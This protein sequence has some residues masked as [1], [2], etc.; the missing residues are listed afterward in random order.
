M[1]HLEEAEN[2]EKRVVGVREEDESVGLRLRF[3]RERG[4]RSRGRRRQAMCKGRRG[5]VSGRIIGS[6]DREKAGGCV[7]GRREGVTAERDR[8]WC[9]EDGEGG[10]A[11]F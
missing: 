5:G 8:W 1:R 7:G 4:A 10:G 11:A 2:E 9:V 3:G 6:F